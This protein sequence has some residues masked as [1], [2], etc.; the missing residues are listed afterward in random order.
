MD[1]PSRYT[2]ITVHRPSLDVVMD[3]QLRYTCTI[4]HRPSLDVVMDRQLRYT[5]ITVQRPSQDVVMMVMVSSTSVTGP[6]HGQTTDLYLYSKDNWPIPVQQRQL[7]YTCTTLQSPSK[8]VVMMVMVSSTSV[9]GRGQGQTNDVYLYNKDNWHI[10][11]HHFN[12]HQR[13]WSWWSQSVQC[14]SHDVVMMVII[15]QRF[16]KGDYPANS[17]V[18]FCPNKQ[19]KSETWMTTSV[20][21]QDPNT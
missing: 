18:A 9:T 7:T 8:D 2:C 21:K 15:R 17:H 10:P 6:G 16:H 5:C 13:M 3:R 20:L 4:F 12:V 11:V 19:R 14:P 1:R